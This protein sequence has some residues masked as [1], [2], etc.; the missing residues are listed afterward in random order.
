[1]HMHTQRQLEIARRAARRRALE[2]KA[3][4]TQ[5]GDSGPT[6]TPQSSVDSNQNDASLWSNFD[7]WICRLTQ[8]A[9]WN[10]LLWLQPPNLGSG[11]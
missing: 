2:S 3:S 5:R 6:L 1:M 9:P 4:S 7:L 10:E 11:L 8:D